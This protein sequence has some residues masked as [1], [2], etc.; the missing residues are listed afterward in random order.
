MAK[1]A[2]NK[3]MAYGLVAVQ[4]SPNPSKHAPIIMD[5]PPHTHRGNE[6]EDDR[7]TLSVKYS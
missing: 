2:N 4:A 6:S 5:P 3:S 1:H 7:E